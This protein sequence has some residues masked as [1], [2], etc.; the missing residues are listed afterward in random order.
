MDEMMSNDVQIRAMED[1]DTE[2]VIA[3]W[4][5]TGVTRPWND[6]H[7]DIAFARRGPHST[8]LVAI[9][10]LAV[11]A[12]SM[13]GEDGHR[14][15]VYYVTA[16]P[17]LQGTGLGRAIMT[18]AEAWLQARGVWKVQLMVRG[19]NTVAQEFY[20]RLG[21]KLADVVCFQKNFSQ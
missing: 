5:A 17:K 21:Y 19:D 3:L 11:V 16:D 20:T 2:Q 8:I 9:I 18:A 14:G 1:R 12:T 4:H 6:P 15:W 13:V 10:D 7:K